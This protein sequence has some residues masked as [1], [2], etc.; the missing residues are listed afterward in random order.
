MTACKGWPYQS[1]RA[2]SSRTTE[3]SCR[4]SDGSRALSDVPAIG[5]ESISRT[6]EPTGSS[7]ANSGN[8]GIDMNVNLQAQRRPGHPGQR[9][10]L[11]WYR[12]PIGLGTLIHHAAPAPSAVL[13]LPVAVI[14]A[15]TI[16]LLVRAAPAGLTPGAPQ[17]ST[18]ASST[19]SADHSA[20]RPEIPPSRADSAAREARARL[21]PATQNLVIVGASCDARAPHAD[22]AIAVLRRLGLLLR[23]S[24]FLGWRRRSMLPGR[25]RPRIQRP[26]QTAIPRAFHARDPADLGD[27]FHLCRC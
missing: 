22:G 26:R 9:L 16:T 2:S 17:P 8:E 15:P 12:R 7:A 21:T 23:A 24:Y 25:T 5:S 14:L 11:P 20:D 3:R 4:G 27:R 18:R 10:H 19:G 13:A 6:C 1:A